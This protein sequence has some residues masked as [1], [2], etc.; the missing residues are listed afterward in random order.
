MVGEA[1]EEV[2]AARAPV[3]EQALAGR[4][5]RLD[6]CAVRRTGAGD[7]LRRLFLDPA[8]CRDVLIRA[9]QDPGLACPGLR[10]EVGLPLREAMRAVGQ[11]GRHVRRAPIAHCAL[12]HGQRKA[13]DL[14]EDDARSVGSHALSRAAGDAIND[15]NRVGVVLV[16]AEDDVEEHPNRRRD[17]GDRERRPE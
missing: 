12:Q 8:K 3:C 13:V 14:E 5:P 9:Q 1:G 6:L 15:A 17:E 10:G 16:R 7:Q 11:P 2:A 4:V